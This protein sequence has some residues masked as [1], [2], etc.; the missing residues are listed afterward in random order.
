MLARILPILALLVLCVLGYFL[1]TQGTIQRIVRPT[2]AAVETKRQLVEGQKIRK[3]FVEIKEIAITRVEPG[4]ITFPSGATATDVEKVLSGQ[5]V[6]RNVEK[7]R[8]L[9]SAMLGESSAAVVLRAISDIREGESLS[10]ENIAAST[11]DVA[12][13]AGAIVFDSEEQAALY[14]SKAYDLAARKMIFAGQILTVDDTAGGAEK[15]FVVRT[16]RPFSRSERLSINGLEAAEVSARD[17]PAGALA[18]QTR[19][20]TDVFITEAGK[21]VLSHPVDAGETVTADMISNETMEQQ[22]DPSDLPRTLA[23]LTSYMKAY[24]DRAMFLDSTTYL[25]DRIEPGQKVDIWVEGGRTGGAFGV[26]RMDRLAESIMVRKAVDDSAPAPKEKET[27]G[28]APAEAARTEK[29]PGEREFFWVAMDSSVKRTFDGARASGGI[30]FSIRDGEVLVD[31]LGNG[32]ACIEGRCQVN[33]KASEDLKVIQAALAADPEEVIEGDGP[34]QDP[35]AVMDGVS[36]ELEDRLRRNGY[37][38]FEIIAAW[39]DREIPAVTI[40]LDISNNLA[41]YI[42]EQARIL[43]SS[44]EEAAR[45][46]GFEEAPTE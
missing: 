2:V 40:K 29:D 18:F 26:I 14:I 45:D 25:G 22:G 24:P 31:V 34:E 23:E 10:L 41:I 36:P 28:D 19:G 38:S 12:P 9:R 13:P 11:H 16:S 7:G 30:A 15:I 32:A 8:F 46:L 43:S 17:L 21:Y 27:D 20:A 4:M 3:S 44:A 39:S 35:L 37:G 6:S 33:R 42:R 1:Y 5:S